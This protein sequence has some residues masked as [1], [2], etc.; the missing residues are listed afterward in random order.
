LCMNDVIRKLTAAQALE[1]VKRLSEKG[2]EI[3][4]AV[5]TEAKNVLVEINLDET[6]DEVFFALDSIDVQD[7]WDRSGSSRNGYTHPMKRRLKSWRKNYSR[8][9]TKPDDT[10][11]WVCPSKRRPT[12][13]E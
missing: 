12:A 13:W 11:S 5:L 10:M 4:E 6:A 9:S 7:C 1:V 2:G 8:F 3:R